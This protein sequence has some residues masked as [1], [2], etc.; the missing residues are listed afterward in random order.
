LKACSK[1]EMLFWEAPEWFLDAVGSGDP[2]VDD[3]HLR[4]AAVEPCN[5]FW[6]LARVP[7]ADLVR[8][9]PAPWIRRL[10]L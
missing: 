8:R 10:T 9:I 5:G 2:K 3:S 1:V 4:Q 7:M 6:L